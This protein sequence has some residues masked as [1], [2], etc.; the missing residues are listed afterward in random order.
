MRGLAMLTDRLRQIEAVVE[1]HSRRMNNMMR[2]GK[3]VETF[4]K[5]GL[6]RVE[7]DGMRSKKVPWATRAGDIK[8][9]SPPRVGERIMLF[10]PTGEP[11]QGVVYPG[12]YSDEYNENHDKDSEDVLTIGNSKIHVKDG[13]IVIKVGGSTVTITE[14]KILMTSDE[15]ATDGKTVLD[16]GSK[17]VHRVDDIDSAMDIAM[18]GAP[19]VYA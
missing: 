1:D 11:G 19:R 18:T 7:M 9:W 12:G 10:S 15:I 8:H 6:V 16:G 3:V 17:K 2:E 5:E 14:D 13:E 4:P